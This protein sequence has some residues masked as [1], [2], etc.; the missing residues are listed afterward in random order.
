[1]GL[2]PRLGLTLPL[3]GRV[4]QLRRLQAALDD[5]EH[6]RGRG[7][8]LAGDAGVG[9]T[10]LLKEVTSE[11]AR[12]GCLVLTGQCLDVDEGGLPYLP[13]TEAL[14]A[15]AASDDPDVLDAL[16]AWPA[17]STLVPQLWVAPSGRQRPGRSAASEQDVRRVRTEHDLGQLRLFDAVLGV[18]DA[19]A[20]TRPVVLALEDVHWAD[21]ATR[22]LLSFLMGRLGGRRLLVLASYRA[23]EVHRRHPLRPLLAELVR[24]AAVE[25]VDVP[26]LSDD[27]ARA[28]LTALAESP[29]PPDTLDQLV[30]RCEGNPFFAEELVA[31]GA[32]GDNMPDGL[33]DVLLTR[34]D[35]LSP[36]TRG[37]LRAVAVASTRVADTAVAEVAGVGEL[38]VEDA[39]REAVHHH[40]LVVERGGYRFR[41]ALLREAVY[42]DLLPGERS[43]MHAAYAARIA[44]LPPSRGSDARLAYHSLRCRDLPTALAALLRAADEAEELGAPGS[45]LRHVEEALEI[46]DAVPVERRP[47]DRSETT[48]LLSA[49]ELAARSGEPER[50]I[51]FAREATRRVDGSPAVRQAAIWRRLAEALMT[52]EGTYDEAVDAIDRAWAL[53][54]DGEPT[55]EQAWV[56]ATRAQVLRGV[57]RLDDAETSARAA[58]DAAKAAGADAPHAAAL[59]IQGVLADVR[60]DVETARELLMQAEREAQAV[61]ALDVELR[62]GYY[63]ALSYDDR[64][65]LPDALRLYRH[66][67][68]RA[69][70]S[71]LTWSPL[72][73]S[74][75]TRLLALRYTIGDWP[76]EAEQDR[77]ESGVSDLVTAILQSTWLHLLV[78]R[79]RF[80]DAE[81][82]LDLLYPEDGDRR[83]VDLWV[84]AAVAAGGAELALWRGEYRRAVDAVVDGM[85]RVQR[86]LADGLLNVR[87]GALGIEACAAWAADARRRRDADGAETAVETG[88]GLWDQVQRTV[89]KGV[90]RS[91]TLGPEGRAWLARARAAAED[92]GGVRDAALWDEA[93]GAFGFGAVYEQALCRR[94]LAQALLDAGEHERAADALAAS[95]EVARRLGARPLREAVE[96]LARRARIELPGARPRRDVVNPLTA[97]ERAVLEHVAD[98]LTNRQVGERLF[99]SE[100][101]VSV[102]LSRAMAKL[103]AN[104]RAEAVAIAYDRGLLTP[105]SEAEGR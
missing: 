29:L 16:A 23:E 67:A 69:S 57:G 1:M 5:A 31:A 92:L 103:G 70:E 2:V 46:W 54:S 56:F 38:D 84:V 64:A 105:E 21:G 74:A 60:G 40:V 100:K 101:T 50:A 72:G 9:K 95:H 61:D 63:R 78:A 58:A 65:E 89:E 19:L 97:R 98:G 62:A 80:D 88:R 47:P 32:S 75:R 42:H 12:R 30:R 43:R 93:V 85:E 24:S 76:D 20:R 15:L 18:L 39:L 83:G 66:T 53:V 86:I 33:A 6:G 44:A 51:A 22:D 14:G 77:P 68:K 55:T 82:M 11:A 4:P 28:F 35:Q 45:A 37:V 96:D 17:L 99:I 104:R 7:A 25:R 3:V 49:S 41:H 10:R 71:G 48:L 90:P 94:Y 59:T 27:E 34:L 13:F 87:L 102:H 79:G 8:L 91:G 26:P 73:L 81:R 52:L 36:R